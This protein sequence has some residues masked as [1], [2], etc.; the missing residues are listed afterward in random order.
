MVKFTLMQ[1]IM[2]KKNWKPA[3]KN[4]MKEAE[5]SFGN[6]LTING[7]WFLKT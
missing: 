2:L 6:L 7:F 3:V 4:E 5:P 1:K